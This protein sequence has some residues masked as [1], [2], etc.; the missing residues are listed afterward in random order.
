MAR[1]PITA[2]G[3]GLFR[4]QLDAAL[5]Y[6]EG[7]SGGGGGGLGNI[8]GSIV[9]T[10]TSSAYA[11]TTPAAIGSYANGQRF[12]FYAHTTCAAN[13]TINVDGVGA[14]GLEY[15]DPTGRSPVY[16]G[17]IQATGIY[18]IAYNAGNAAFMLLNPTWPV[19]SI[20]TEGSALVPFSSGDT[21]E[22]LRADGT[23]A[24]PGGS[25]TI[26]EGL[27][28][29]TVPNNRL[30][31]SETVAATG[32]TGASRVFL[33]IAPHDDADEN[34]AEMLDIAAMSAAPGTGQITVELAFA[35][36]VAGAIKL[37][38]MAL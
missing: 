20:D 29:V 3:E 10:G 9:S 15:N 22:F 12:A 6:V 1:P 7:L 8:S 28:T 13:P 34:D 27:A 35:V 31:W 14:V 16:A 26:L 24:V 4:R 18:D 38:W 21:A 17:M 32:V 25:S 36:P 11:I 23:W 37:N 30:E 33:S 5:D 19:I 2:K